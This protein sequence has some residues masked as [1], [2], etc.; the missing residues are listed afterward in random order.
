MSA[1][2]GAR[3]D[4]IIDA[5]EP[6]LEFCMNDERYFE[7]KVERASVL[8]SLTTIV[9]DGPRTLYSFCDHDAKDK[10]KAGRCS[11]WTHE[12]VIR[13][14]LEG[15]KRLPAD[16]RGGPFKASARQRLAIKTEWKN[17]DLVR[18][19][20]IPEGAYLRVL[21]SMAQSQADGKQTESADHEAL[22]EQEA[23]Q[24]PHA[25]SV[26]RHYDAFAGPR[27]AGGGIQYLLYAQMAEAGGCSVSLAEPLVTFLARM[28]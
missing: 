19:L 6:L 5:I 20:T 21:V 3:N 8:M 25:A 4:E 9:L 14:M 1:V 15:V 17:L 24:F 7:Q 23:V 12:N 27:Y 10:D 11:W 22:A 16:A 18:M 2:T 13:E 28:A 26:D